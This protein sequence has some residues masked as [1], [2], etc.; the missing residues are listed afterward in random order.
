MNTVLLWS[1]HFLFFFKWQKKTSIS[2]G[3]CFLHFCHCNF[4]LW[5]LLIYLTDIQYIAHR[6]ILCGVS[7]FWKPNKDIAFTANESI[8]LIPG[9]SVRYSLAN[10][11]VV[12]HT[13]WNFKPMSEDGNV[14]YA[15]WETSVDCSTWMQLNLNQKGKYTN[16]LLKQNW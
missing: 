4:F 5:R 1:Y 15:K 2:T 9:I 7:S 14:M 3:F 13:E 6:L 12:K 8:G 10:E 11:G 16:W